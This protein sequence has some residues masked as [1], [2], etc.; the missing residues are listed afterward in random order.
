MARTGPLECAASHD[1]RSLGLDPPV[2]KRRIVNCAEV[3]DQPPAVL[4]QNPKPMMHANQMTPTRT[5]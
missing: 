4:I 3:L 2:G 5:V 1:H